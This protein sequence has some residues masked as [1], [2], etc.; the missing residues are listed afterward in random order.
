MVSPHTGYFGDYRARY[1]VPM[2]LLWHGVMPL[3]TWMFGYFPG[4]SLRLGEDL[5]AGFAMQWA[6][7][8]LPEMRMAGGRASLDRMGG[9]LGNCA[10]LERPALV[11][12]VSDDAFAT[13]A[14]AQ[15]ILGYL[16][17][18]T[19]S[20][21]VFVPAEANLE[22]LGHFGFFRQHGGPVLWPKLLAA[23]DPRITPLP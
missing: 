3:L 16:P 21:I 5:P 7:R 10:V 22:H 15:R 1:R 13:E 4:R 18:L 14:G 19:S 17:R 23:I 11:V 2:G 9:V 6:G 8:L 20:H 12:T